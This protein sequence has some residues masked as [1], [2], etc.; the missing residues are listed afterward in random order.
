MSLSK[1]RKLVEHAQRFGFFA[2]SLAEKARKKYDDGASEK[3]FADPNSGRS[4]LLDTYLPVQSYGP[5]G[6]QMRRNILD[7]WWKHSVTLQDNVF[8]LFVADD[9]DYTTTSL[10]RSLLSIKPRADSCYEGF[11]KILSSDE[12]GIAQVTSASQTNHPI[13]PSSIIR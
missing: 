5:L 8:P 3:R 6:S 4:S 9:N 12:I 10:Q 7:S 11:A 13:N 1:I 2:E